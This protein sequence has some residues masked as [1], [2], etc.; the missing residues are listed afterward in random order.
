MS[1]VDC[2]TTRITEYP[3]D[4]VTGHRET[5]PFHIKPFSFENPV[6]TGDRASVLCSVKK[7]RNLRY[8]WLKDGHGLYSRSGLVIDSG[9]GGETLTI[10]SVSTEH[11]GNYTCIVTDGHQEESFAAQLQVLGKSWLRTYQELD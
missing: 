10:E 8:R 4:T 9:A 2:T 1:N 6:V 3:S 5:Q 11:E 7:G